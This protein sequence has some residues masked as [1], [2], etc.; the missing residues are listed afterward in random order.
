MHA[1]KIGGASHTHDIRNAV[2]DVYFDYIIQLSVRVCHCSDACTN[3]SLLYPTQRPREPGYAAS[4]TL[5]K[6]A[7][8]R[9]RRLAWN[10]QLSGLQ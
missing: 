6:L 3:I 2:T 7:L 9:L 1:Q 8:K 5:T 4:I 10:L